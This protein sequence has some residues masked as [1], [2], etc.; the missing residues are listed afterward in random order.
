MHM[1]DIMDDTPSK[2]RPLGGT[3]SGNV[4]AMTHGAYSKRLLSD[5]EAR[6]YSDLTALLKRDFPDLDDQRIK[7]TAL[8][9]IRLYRTVDLDNVEAME[10]LDSKLRK[11]L[12]QLRKPPKMPDDLDHPDSCE[13]WLNRWKE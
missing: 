9:F 5:D 7:D 12:K 4:N 6:A 2:K 13:E 10:K 3:P 1:T 11:H 8:C